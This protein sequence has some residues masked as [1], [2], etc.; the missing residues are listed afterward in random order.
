MTL[1]TTSQLAIDFPVD[2]ASLPQTVTKIDTLTKRG[3]LVG[4]ELVQ[5]LGVVGAAMDALAEPVTAPTGVYSG[6]AGAIT[7]AYALLAEYPLAQSAPSMDITT[8]FNAVEHSVLAQYANLEG[9]AVDA[10]SLGGQPLE[11]R[12]T[13]GLQRSKRYGDLSSVLLV[14]STSALSASN[15]VTVTTPAFSSVPSPLSDPRTANTMRT[16]PNSPAPRASPARQT[17]RPA[18]PGRAGCAS[19]SPAIV[20]STW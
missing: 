10:I 3:Y 9:R 14:T 17:G 12:G 13:N 6:S 5:A 16:R 15:F 2:N 19:A 4:P 1:R 20:L 7:Q 18:G 8:G 11:G